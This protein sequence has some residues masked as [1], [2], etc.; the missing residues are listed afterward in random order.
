MAGWPIS[1]MRCWG[2]CRGVLERHDVNSIDP[3]VAQIGDG[4]IVGEDLGEPGAAN[5]WASCR[6]PCT[7]PGPTA[8]RDIGF[9]NCV[10][11]A[12]GVAGGRH[13]RAAT[14]SV[15]PGVCR[16][17]QDPGT[18][19]PRPLRQLVIT[20]RSIEILRRLAY[21]AE[22]SASCAGH[23]PSSIA[24]GRCR[25]DNKMNPRWRRSHCSQSGDPLLA[26]PARSGTLGG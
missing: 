6:A 11:R 16:C 3:D 20:P 4:R 19:V 8:I 15:P 24:F 1:T 10:H 17:T 22:R 13:R 12:V 26:R 14:V 23:V 9:G 25:A 7:G 5:A 18:L 2:R 21:L